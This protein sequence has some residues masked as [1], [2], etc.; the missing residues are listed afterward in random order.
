VLD[1]VAAAVV[2]LADPVDQVD[3]AAV[4]VVVAGLVAADLRQ[5]D[6]L[7]SNKEETEKGGK[8]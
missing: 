7:S 4:V 2:L 6:L 3:P 5:A 8:I 1:A